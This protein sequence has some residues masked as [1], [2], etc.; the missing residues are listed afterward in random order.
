MRVRSVK[1][2]STRTASTPATVQMSQRKRAGFRLFLRLTNRYT[3]MTF[4][5]TV[6]FLLSW[7]LASRYINPLLLPSPSSIAVAF[8]RMLDAGDLVG[9][10]GTSLQSFA[11]GVILAIIFGV[12]GGLLLGRYRMLQALFGH[13]VNALY[14]TPNVA[15]VPLIILWFGLGRSAQIVVVFLSSTF[16]V[17]YNASA[18]V[19]SVSKHHVDVARA[20][21]ANERTIFL[22]VTIPSS[23]PFIMAGI[24]LGLGRGLVGMIVAEMFIAISGMGGAILRFSNALQT[25]EMFVLILILALL[26]VVLLQFG[27]YL[28]QRFASWKQTEKAF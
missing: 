19:Q 14:A 13:Y 9:L 18:G 27:S 17:L 7:Q 23:L 4:G 5:S 10:V 21:G 3:L 28:E 12:L 24:R 20:Y 2:D 16:P 25:A 15:L 11:I 1:M 8:R 26:G 6:V 22:D